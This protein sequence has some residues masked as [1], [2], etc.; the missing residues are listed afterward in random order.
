MENGV[1]F[2]QVSFFAGEQFAGIADAQHRAEDWCRIRA[3][4]RVHGTTRPRPAEV[5]VQLEAPALL[6]APEQPYRVPAWSEA[7]VQRDFHLSGRRTRST[8]CPTA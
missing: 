3:G 2:V 4:M 6:P 5:F 8:R 7:K 1:K